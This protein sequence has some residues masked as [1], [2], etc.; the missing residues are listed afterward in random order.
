MSKRPFKRTLTIKGEKWKLIFRAPRDGDDLLAEIQPGDQGLCSYDN[1]TIYI[2]PNS[3]A[4][5]TGIHEVLHA[6]FP[7]LNE[8]AI[9]NAENVLM[10]YLA[11]FPEELHSVD[12]EGIEL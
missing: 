8:D 3:E 4:V 5:G 12:E 7:D 1:K 10:D 2:A 11:V 6:C 9:T